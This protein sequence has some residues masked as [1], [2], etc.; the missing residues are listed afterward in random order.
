MKNNDKLV[1][2][3]HKYLK[4]DHNTILHININDECINHLENK[5][6]NTVFIKQE[7]VQDNGK[8]YDII[9][10]STKKDSPLS[11]LIEDI[12]KYSKKDQQYIIQVPKDFM[13]DSFVR[14][15]NSEEFDI[16][17]NTKD[18]FYYIWTK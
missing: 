12:K 3:I 5:I 13:F 9:L 15:I 1:N 16:Y 8:I 2:L 14:S 6:K 17:N 18:D 11:G 4:H 7:N 10:I